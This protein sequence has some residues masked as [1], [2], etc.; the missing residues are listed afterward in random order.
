MSNKE[1]PE[2]TLFDLYRAFHAEVAG[3]V[4]RTEDSWNVMYDWIVQGRRAQFQA[5]FLEGKLI[6]ASMFIDGKETSIYASGVYDRTQ[7]DKPLGHYPLWLG[8]ERAQARG[9]KVLELGEVPERG[10]ASEKEYQIGY[11]KRGFAT[12][13]ETQRV[14]H[15]SIGS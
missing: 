6:A 15:W 13:I 10:A 7:F 9:M 5:A 4:T 11:F 12:H 14:W 1:M 3:R 2:R 8:I